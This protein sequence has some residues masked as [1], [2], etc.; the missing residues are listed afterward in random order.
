MGLIVVTE[1]PHTRETA[2]TKKQPV[3]L[4]EQTQPRLSLEQLSNDKEKAL[5]LRVKYYAPERPKRPRLPPFKPYNLKCGIF[6]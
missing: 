4:H 2:P 1:P 3:I 5:C 6:A